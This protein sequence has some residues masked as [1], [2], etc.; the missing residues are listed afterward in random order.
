MCAVLGNHF[1]T[2]E[3]AHRIPTRPRGSGEPSSI[4]LDAYV[5]PFGV[6]YMRLCAPHITS[7][8]L[9]QTDAANRHADGDVCRRGI[10]RSVNALQLA[11]CA[12]TKESH[13]WKKK[14]AYQSPGKRAGHRGRYADRLKCARAASYFLI[15]GARAHRHF[16]TEESKETDTGDARIS[17]DRFSPGCASISRSGDLARCAG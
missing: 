17:V 1:F 13:H 11:R 16:S 14:I 9:A 7:V 4:N 5:D 3:S 2:S 8:E 10:A 15:A 12:S 6:T